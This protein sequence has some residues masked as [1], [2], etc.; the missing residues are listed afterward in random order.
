MLLDKFSGRP[1][2]QDVRGMLQ[3][4]LVSGVGCRPNKQ[5]QLSVS[6]F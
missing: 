6:S 2:Y 4:S 5:M 1:L 3:A